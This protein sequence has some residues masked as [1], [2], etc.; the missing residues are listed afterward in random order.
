[1][2]DH[3]AVSLDSRCQGTVPV[4]NVIG[5]AFV[6]VW[7]SSRWDTLSVPST[8]DGVPG[9]VAMPAGRTPVPGSGTSATTPAGEPAG[10]TAQDGLPFV[11]G[12]PILASG[13]LGFSRIRS[14]ISARSVRI[15]RRRR[16]TL[17]S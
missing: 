13:L 10:R 3:R 8:F 12:L 17:P 4:E 7:P 16:R 5:R 11:V 15:H 2:G 14:L 6:I 9:P 1:M